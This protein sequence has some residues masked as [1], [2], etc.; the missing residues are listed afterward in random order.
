MNLATRCTSCGTIFRIVEDQLRVSDGWVRCGRC[1]EVFDARELLFDIEQDPPPAWPVAYSPPPAAPV[2]PPAPIAPAPSPAWPPAVQPAAAPIEDDTEVSWAAPTPAE[3]HL[4]PGF[5]TPAPRGIEADDRHEPRWVEP[6]IT[7]AGA[8]APEPDSLAAADTRALEDEPAE[9]ASAVPEFMRAAHSDA[10]WRRPGVR[11]ALGV[12]SL[13][14]LTLLMAQIAVHF[15][16]AIVA[17]HPPLRDTI[18]ALC[19]VASCEIGPWQ[20]IDALSI[21]TTALNPAGAGNVYRLN[22]TVRNKAPV[23]LAAPWVELSLTDAAGK[24]LSRRALPPSSL[25]PSLDRLAPEAEQ[26]LQFS[27]GTGD[28]KVSGYSVNIFYP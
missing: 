26:A 22:L 27:F 28:Q 12:V 25:S 2:P 24:V 10:R 14:L 18:Q 1:A 4:E 8:T 13:L 21:E 9:S 5:G 19:R 16:A 15:R 7:P 17:L 3:H 23:E 20:R 6:A 11:A